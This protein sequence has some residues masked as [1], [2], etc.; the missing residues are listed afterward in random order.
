MSGVAVP[1]WWSRVTC[2]SAAVFKKTW[3]SK[4]LVSICEES[5]HFCHHYY[6]RRLARERGMV[7]AIEWH[8]SGTRYRAREKPALTE[9]YK[10]VVNAMKNDRRHL[11]QRQQVYDVNA[12]RP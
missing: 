8:K 6:P 1:P 9:R 10:M 5:F 7:L 4:E 12:S 11:D 2:R 3:L